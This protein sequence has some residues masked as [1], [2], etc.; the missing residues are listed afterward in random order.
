MKY[1]R[2][3]G[4]QLNDHDSYC[5]RCGLPTRNQYHYYDHFNMINMHHHLPFSCMLA[6][7]PGLFFIPLIT[8]FNDKTHRQCANQGLLITILTVV[9]VMI[10][11]YFISQI[12]WQHLF[13]LYQYW[14]TDKMKDLIVLNCIILP[15]GCYVPINSLTGF[16]RGTI[17]SIPYRIPFF[18]VFEIIKAEEN[19]Y[20]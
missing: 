8:H 4:Q 9:A 14:D 1:C 6:Y 12:D 2:R 5:S 15:L 10:L 7:I 17:S 20:E 16:F 19:E 3:C 11:L 18:G 13:V